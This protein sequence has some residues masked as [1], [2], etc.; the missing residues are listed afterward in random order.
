GARGESTGDSARQLARGAE[1][2]RQGQDGADGG[3][4]ARAQARTQRADAPAAGS[5]FRQVWRQGPARHSG[6]EPVPLTRPRL[7]DGLEKVPSGAANSCTLTRLTNVW[8]DG[9]TSFDTRR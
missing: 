7:R 3:Q 5:A 9:P 2:G 1:R 4:P 8:A 6:H